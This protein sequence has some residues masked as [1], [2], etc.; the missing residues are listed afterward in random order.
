MGPGELVLVPERDIGCP[1][2]AAARRCD[3]CR[4]LNGDLA[5]FVVEEEE[6]E[7]CAGDW[8]ERW[9]APVEWVEGG[10]AGDEAEKEAGV[11]TEAEVGGRGVG[12]DL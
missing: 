4:W 10:A 11:M 1:P 5:A 8:W 3:C 6:D 2:I 9:P 7:K 12:A